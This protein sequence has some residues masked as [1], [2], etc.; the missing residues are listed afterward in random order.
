[1]LKIEQPLPGQGKRPESHNTYIGVL[2][3]KSFG[4]RNDNVPDTIPGCYG[5]SDGAG[6]F[7]C[8]TCI[9]EAPCSK[10]SKWDK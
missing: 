8:F 6:N 5:E 4:I 2:V 10:I 9:F 3:N 7:G 1:M